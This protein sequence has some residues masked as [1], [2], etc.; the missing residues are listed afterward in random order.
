MEPK[1]LQSC[2]GLPDPLVLLSGE[3]VATPEDWFKRRRPELVELFQHYMYGHMPPAP[4]R[5]ESTTRFVEPKYLGGKATLKEVEVRFG[6]PK[7]PPIR[8]LVA[9]PNGL[10]RPAPAFVGLNFYG[11]H[12][13]VRDPRVALPDVWVRKECPGA[14]ANRATDAG[15]GGR[16]DGWPIEKIVARGYALATF[17]QGDIDPD[18]HDFSDGVHPHYYRPGQLSPLLRCRT[19]T[20]QSSYQR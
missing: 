19:R 10:S 18:L 7:T 15:R 6:P 17:Y 4:Q 2:P 9:S 11:N 14:V 20:L 5:V 12:V 8:L 16:P 1:P 3:R 13:I